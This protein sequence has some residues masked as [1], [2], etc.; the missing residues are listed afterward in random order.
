LKTKRSEIWI[1]GEERDG[2]KRGE[3]IEGGLG[4]DQVARW[5]VNRGE[6]LTAAKM[7][8]ARGEQ[9]YGTEERRG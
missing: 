2:S 4:M 6:L 9:I 8:D 5:F 7:I 3:C 1:S